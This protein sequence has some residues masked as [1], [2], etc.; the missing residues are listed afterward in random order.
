MTK[1]LFARN[2]GPMLRKNVQAEWLYFALE[3]HSKSGAL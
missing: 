3:V 2:A 1:I